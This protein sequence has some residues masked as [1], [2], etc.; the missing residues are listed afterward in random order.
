MIAGVE[1]AGRGPVIGPMV[2]VIL[3]IDEKDEQKL[4]D[5]GVKDSKLLTATQREEIYQSLV[6][7]EHH[8]KILQPNEIDEAVLSEAMNLNWLEAKTTAELISFVKADK[9]ILDC[10]SNNTSAY[11]NYVK[12]LLKKDIEIIAEHKA[13]VKY[14]VVSAASIIAKVTRDREI[15]KLKKKFKV[16]F[17]SG[18]PSDPL[19]ISFLE[20][21][22]KKYDFFRKSW[23]PYK[24]LLKSTQQKTLKGF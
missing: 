12:K 23:A 9:V 10:P 4:V 18:Y 22:Y 8:V 21:N 3:V 19:T 6:N 14:P 2:M 17:G 7:F 15:E 13:D 1:E 11:K 20:K 5:L 16:N 24:K